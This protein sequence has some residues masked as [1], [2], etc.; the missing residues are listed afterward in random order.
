MDAKTYAALACNFLLES[1]EMGERGCYVA[2]MILEDIEKNGQIAPAMREQL[3]GWATT[4]GGESGT[5]AFEIAERMQIT[6]E[7]EIKPNGEENSNKNVV[8]AE[9]IFMRLANDLKGFE[10]I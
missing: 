5:N 2:D 1:L 4:Y 3:A 10:K 9:K 8:E 7:A 6:L